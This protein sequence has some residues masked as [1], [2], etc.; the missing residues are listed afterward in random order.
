MSVGAA[1][2]SRTMFLTSEWLRER[3]SQLEQKAKEA[4]RGAVWLEEYIA[5]PA[6]GQIMAR[7]QTDAPLTPEEVDRWERLLRELAGDEFMIDF[8]GSV[9]R[10]IGV[11]YARLDAICE[12][13]ARRFADEP[14]KRGPYAEQIRQDAQE[15][16]RRC[17]LPDDLPVWEIQYEDGEYSLLLLG[18]E[19]RFIRTVP[20]D[21]P[22]H[23]SEANGALCKGLQQTVF[24]AGRLGVSLGRLMLEAMEA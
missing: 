21:P 4:T 9:Y 11:D 18:R 24:A 12:Q 15:L 10:R 3:F 2:G 1:E 16:L 22:V 17:D 6:F 13:L 23:L 19:N 14:M 8:M 5:V 20:G 7:F